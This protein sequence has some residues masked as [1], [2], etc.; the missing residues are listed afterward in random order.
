MSIWIFYAIA[1]Q[2]LFSIS[3]YIDKILLSK[4]FNSGSAG[5]LVIFSGMTGLLIAGII[6]IFIRPDL[7]ALP[8]SQNALLILQ[9]VLTVLFLIPYFIAMQGS[10]PSKVIPLYQLVPVFSLALEY[11]WLGTTITGRAFSGMMIIALGCY[12]ISINLHAKSLL[13]DYRTLG[14]VAL[15]AL[16]VSISSVI[17][18]A[19][20]AEDHFWIAAF[21]SHLGAGITGFVYLL[22]QTRFQKELKK[23]FRTNAGQVL[24]FNF[25]NEICFVAAMLLMYFAFTVLKAPI[26]LVQSIVG[27]QPAIIFIY[28]I[29]LHYL[30]PNLHQERLTTLDIIQKC[31]AIIILFWG[32]IRIS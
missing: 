27:I 29:A 16:I 22:T 23:M 6:W 14:L 31:S 11:F 20:G 8:N 30:V 9:G 28:G 3:N 2:F 21:Y 7:T 25:C 19:V 10:E 1:A 15:S 24:F 18:K 4:F 5:A 32:T 12:L 26:S 17:F 13:P